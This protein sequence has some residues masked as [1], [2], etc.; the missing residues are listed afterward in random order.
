MFGGHMK[1][2]AHGEVHELC[3]VGTPCAPPFMLTSDL[4]AGLDAAVMDGAYG[5]YV[6]G[7]GPVVPI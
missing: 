3:L 2:G 1:G 4:A 7:K 6:W 5:A